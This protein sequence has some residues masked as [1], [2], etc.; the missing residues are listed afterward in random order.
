MVGL[1]QLGEPLHLD[2]VR[3]A[4]LAKAMVDMIMNKSALGGDDGFFHGLELHRDIGAGSTFLD[5]AN[6]MTQMAVRS[7]QPFDQSS[8]GCVLMGFRHSYCA[9]PGI[10]P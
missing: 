3:C 10:L 8:M 6:D 2:K 4:A 9:S 1:K 7:L 5:H